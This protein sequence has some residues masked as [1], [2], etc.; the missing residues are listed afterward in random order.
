[1]N[2]RDSEL[3]SILMPSLVSVEELDRDAWLAHGNAG[4]DAWFRCVRA[5][6]GK[7]G[8][9]SF[10][11]DINGVLPVI[12]AGHSGAV[13]VQ[14][15]TAFMDGTLLSV[16]GQVGNRRA[17]TGNDQGVSRG[18]RRMLRHE[19]RTRRAEEAAATRGLRI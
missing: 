3:I 7:L 16:E 6:A 13:C 9:N 17:C 18:R 11:S 10:W 14:E 1:M 4:G 2:A 19:P 12:M 5:K 15:T 8:L